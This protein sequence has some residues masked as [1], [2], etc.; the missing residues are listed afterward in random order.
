MNCLASASLHSGEK[1]APSKSGTKHLVLGPPG[2]LG[3]FRYRMR[4]SGPKFIPVEGQISVDL[5][6]FDITLS[7]R[8]A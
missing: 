1:S 3:G 7:L 2:E 4:D 5:C 8:I 6:S